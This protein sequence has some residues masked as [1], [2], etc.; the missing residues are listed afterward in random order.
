[1]R[2]INDCNPLR[3]SPAI[4]L[5]PE[6]YATCSTGRRRKIRMKFNKLGHLVLISAAALVVSTLLAACTSRTV[7]FV[8][9]ASS[10][11][12][13]PNSYGQIDVMKLDS[14]SGTLVALPTSP[15]PSGGR[16]PV[17]EVVS[18]DGKYLYVINHDDNTIV[19]FLIGSDGK[20]YQQ[21]TVNTPGIFPLAVAIDPGNKFLYVLDT[22]QPLP[23]CSNANPCAGSIAVFQILTGSAAIAAHV[24]DGEPFSGTYLPLSIG[25]DLVN[26]TALTLAA[27]GGFLYV[28]AVDA[29][30]APL[31]TTTAGYVFGFRVNPAAST[32]SGVLTP[33]AGQPFIAVG[34]KPTG[35]TSVPTTAGSGYSLF[36]SDG[37]NLAAAPNNTNLFRLSSAAD[38]SLTAAGA[39]SAGNE[40]S[41][42]AADHVG[43]FLYVTN[44]T[45]SNISAFAVSDA[46]VR[47][48]GNY[49]T[50]AQPVAILVDPHLGEFVFTANFLGSNAVGN[51]SGFLINATPS[52]GSA[53]VAGSLINAQSSPFITNAQPTALAAVP[54]NLH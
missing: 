10:K 18:P 43:S 2:L 52:S 12:A 53:S 42:L 45:D 49:A 6:P 4:E 30:I 50:G 19:Q 36:V 26:P 33:I 41:A 8:Y 16:N 25:T 1:M 14:R 48:I 34:I 29:T 28:A 32:T 46:A 20:I 44:A 38:G 23:T 51:V 9:I 39:Y 11:A 40:P 37:V 3:L 5:K 22:Y 13:G 7:D 35:I 54:H 15:F 47:F 24:P 17:A 31:A 21:S 27:N